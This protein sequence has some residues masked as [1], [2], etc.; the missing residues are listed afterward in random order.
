MMEVVDTMDIIRKIKKLWSGKRGLTPKSEV[1]LRNRE[2]EGLVPQRMAAYEDVRLFVSRYIGF[3]TTAFRDSVPEDDPGDLEGF[4]S[5]SGMPK[6]FH[7]LYMDSEPDVSPPRPYWEWIVENVEEFS[8][9]GDKVL[10]RHELLLGPSVHAQIHQLTKCSFNRM[11]SLLPVHLNSDLKD[12]Y[13][14]IRILYS[15]SEP[16]VKEDFEAALGLFGWCE[17]QYR[18]LRKKN[19]S[20]DRVAQ[21]SPMGDKK[22]PPKCLI[23]ESVL[24]EQAEV[25]DEFQNRDGEL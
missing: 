19:P 4:F 16:P 24:K 13:P 12:G 18:Q 22:Y 21:Y 6:I 2:K 15:Y 14:R 9:I 1:L 23:P 3:W 10:A 8:K 11:L 7:N 25:F 17:T 5:E 20:I